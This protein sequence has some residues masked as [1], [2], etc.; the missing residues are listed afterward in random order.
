MRLRAIQSSFNGGELSARM[1]ARTD[2]AIYPISCAEMENFTPAVEGPAVKRSGFRYIK[3]AMASASWLSSFIYSVT[4]AYV[5]EWGSQVLRFYTNGGRIDVAGAAYEVV[6]PYT[7]AQAPFVS[8]QQSYDRIYM[9]HPSHPPAALARIGATSFS[10]SNVVLKNGP[11]QTLN[12]DEARTVTL[13]GALTVGGVATITASSA[14]FL[15]GHI[16]G[17]VLVEAKSFSDIKAWEPNVRTNTIAVGDKR[18]SDGKVYE[19]EDKGASIRT[20]T[21]QPTHVRGSEWDGSGQ[22]APATVDDVTGIKWKYLYDRYGIGTITAIGGG[23]TTATVTVTR[24]F[25]A[26]LTS[27]ASFLWRLPAI[28]AATGWPRVNVLAFSRLI[29]F[30][31]F[32]MMASVV[33]DYG[34]GSV[35]MSPYTDGGLLAPDQAFTRRLSISN[36]VL[37]A[38]LDRGVILIGTADGTYAIQKVNPND[39]FSSD[40]IE[41]VKQ[42]HNGCEPVEPVQSGVST[43]YVQR[44]GRKLREAGF[45]FQSDRYAAPNLNVWQ[46]HILKGGAKQLAFLSSPDELLCAVR[47]DGLLAVH[48]HVPEQEVRGFARTRH[49]GGSIRSATVIPSDAEADEYW[50][51]VENESGV[52]SVELQ[53]APWE[54]EETDLA[55]AF[56]VDSGVSYDGVPIATISIGVDHLI[57]KSVRILADGKVLPAQTVQASNPKLSFPAAS[58]IHVGLGYAARLKW[59]RPEA[60]GS[61]GQ[62]IQGKRQRVVALIARL[63][64]TVGLTFDPGTGRIDQLLKRG[65]STAM[66]AAPAPF[67]GDTESQAVGGEWNRHGQ[68]SFIHEDPT[69]CIIVGSIPTLE[70]E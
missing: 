30:N 50:V 26:N 5:L 38:K 21:V 22:A 20:G 15:A 13:A 49:A 62:T 3:A 66:D 16:G 35:N 56:F 25:A 37:W 34:G 32:E 58:K 47:G 45:N 40:N 7:A 46:R 6:T 67:T 48:P 18:R 51:L 12:T 8:Q 69:P 14:I 29:Y 53:A 41:C 63:L 17:P 42:H 4:Q 55:D 43:I 11:F 9:A 44:G 1:H 65:A 27:V 23:G 64:D 24:A 10:H 33:G 60:R 61:D 70:V 54:E 19:C 52:K 68:G 31:D 57:G 2:Q 36:P 59:L 28:C 39:V